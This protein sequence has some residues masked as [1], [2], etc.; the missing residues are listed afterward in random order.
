MAEEKICYGFFLFVITHRVGTEFSSTPSLPS[1]GNARAHRSFDGRKFEDNENDLKSVTCASS[2][3]NRRKTERPEIGRVH[4]PPFVH[5]RY[6]NTTTLLIM[7]VTHGQ[8]P[9]FPHVFRTSYFLYAAS[10]SSLPVPCSHS[11]LN[12]FLSIPGGA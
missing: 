11:A 4:G 1:E 9:N 6:D 5:D 12:Y 2:T 7:Y 3:G 10:N 8:S